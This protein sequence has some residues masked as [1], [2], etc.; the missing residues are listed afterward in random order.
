M[1]AE[2]GLSSLKLAD[3]SSLT[4]ESHTTAPLKDEM[5]QLTTGFEKRTGRHH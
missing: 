3:G 2:Q 4:L 1:L 5:N